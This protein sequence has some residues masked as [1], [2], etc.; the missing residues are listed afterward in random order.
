M[1]KNRQLIWLIVITACIRAFIA[2]TLE[3]GN[4][5]VYYY[6]YALHLQ[7]N[8]FDHPPVIALLIRLTTFN[9]NV[10]SELFVRA[11]SI[12]GAAAGTWLCFA[13]GRHIANERT[14]WFAAI[15]YN[16]SIYTSIIAGT[17]I[18]PDSPQVVCWLAT[19]FSA[20]K[21]IDNFNKTGKAPAANWFLFA[22]LTGLCIMCKVH[23]V[24]L[25][26]GLGLYIL[27]YD[28][29]QLG[30]PL[31]YLSFLITL[32]IISPIFFWNFNNHFITWTFHSERVGVSQAG[33]KPD[34]FLQALT[35]QFFYNNPV[36]VILIVI[37]LLKTKK[38]QLLQQPV[39]RLLLL[40]GLPIIIVVTFMS[41][42]NQVLPHWSGPGFMT[43]S[44]F[45]AAFLDK[46]VLSAKK[47]LPVFLKTSAGLLIAVAVTGIGVVKYYPGTLSTSKKLGSQ[48][49]TLDLSGWKG[50][51][52]AYSA[53]ILQHPQ[54][55]ALKIV[56]HNWF[57]ASHLEYY[58][59]RPMH[60]EVV[61]VG[62]LHDLHTFAWLNKYRGDLKK[63]EDAIIIIP[64]N[65]ND[66][67]QLNYGEYFSS[68][69]PLQT[70]VSQRGGRPSRY[71]YVFLARGYKANDE[72]HLI[73][74]K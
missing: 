44:F 49:F 70:F 15:L 65:Y 5:E 46:N 51:E 31:L 53:W 37:S 52:N 3:F 29:K 2:G 18:L 11:G 50:F 27:F 1:R 26:G 21:L 69:T 74:V 38:Q 35:G 19:L 43:L 68:V 24:F 66:D 14:G 61:G 58:V 17:F 7:W 12:I 73:D 20:I 67:V 10:V 34:D 6:I 8:Y 62:K 47:K 39:A 64:S 4:D 60:N 13:V 33:I 45:A 32:L 23:G 22:T 57:P 41:L 56:S 72:A 59:A 48:D 9:L 54:Y 63:G 36:N 42:F 40:M 30:S 55:A 25:W 28:R 16:T 71:F